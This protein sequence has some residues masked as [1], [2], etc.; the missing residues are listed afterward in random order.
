MGNTTLG[1]VEVP[2]TDPEP[3]NYQTLGGLMRVF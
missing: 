3:F 1:G 2:V